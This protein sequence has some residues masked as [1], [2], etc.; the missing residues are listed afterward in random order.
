ML[1]LLLCPREW[2]APH[3]WLPGPFLGCG[4]AKAFGVEGALVGVEMI[5]ELESAGSEIPESFVTVLVISA[6]VSKDC[7]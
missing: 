3:C 7:L 6:T 4:L 1:N 5:E 2:Q